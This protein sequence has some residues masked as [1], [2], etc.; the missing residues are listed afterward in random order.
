MTLFLILLFGTFLFLSL[1]SHAHAIIFLPA[2]IL[3]PIAHF[4]GM[5]I[6][7]FTVPA[8]GLGALWSRMTKTPMRKSITIVVGIL[9]LLAI[10]LTLILKFHNPERPFL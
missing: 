4:V 10:I 2:F 3:I 8:L 7:G 1:P 5:I 9:I 6:A